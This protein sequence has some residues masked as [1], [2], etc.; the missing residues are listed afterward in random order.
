MVV[1]GPGFEPG[2][3]NASGASVRPLCPSSGTPASKK[4]NNPETYK[5]FAC[6]QFWAK[7][8]IIAVLLDNG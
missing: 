3:A 7:G 4:L 8:N 1:R 2:Q 5:I 6:P